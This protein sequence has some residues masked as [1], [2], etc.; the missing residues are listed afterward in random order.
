MLTI[1]DQEI[2]NIVTRVLGQLPKKRDQNHS[3]SH[4]SK[5]KTIAL[6]ADHGGYAMKEMLKSHLE[7]LGHQMIDCGTHSKESV[8]YPDF[9]LSV[10]NKVGQK[11]ACCGI[12]IDGAGIGSCMVANKVDGVRAAMCYD[13]STAVN[14][15]EHNHAN[16][17]TIGAGLI[18]NSLAKQ[19]VDVWLDT[20]YGE[21][22]HAMRVEKIMAVEALA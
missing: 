8:D 7:K 15:R 19:I 5:H 14:S 21:G 12:I 2:Q 16:V 10:A 3:Q 18:G 6:G 1:S 11:E 4:S 17:L 20:E 13:Y 9:A 22:R